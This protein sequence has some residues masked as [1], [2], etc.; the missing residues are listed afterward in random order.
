MK[1]NP[2]LSCNRVGA[3]CRAVNLTIQHSHNE[4]AHNDIEILLNLI[5]S[6]A[7]SLFIAGATLKNLDEELESVGWANSYFQRLTT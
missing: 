1:R 5:S 7:N 2:N 4:H 3:I 6:E